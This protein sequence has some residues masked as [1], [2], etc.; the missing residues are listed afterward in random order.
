[1]P[2]LNGIEYEVVDPHHE[3]INPAKFPSYMEFLEYCTRICYKSDPTEESAEDFVKR[4]S[5]KH[6]SVLEHANCIMDI[7]TVNQ[8]QLLLDVTGVFEKND[9]NQARR[10]FIFRASKDIS[11]SAPGGSVL[12][13][14]G[15]LR[16]WMELMESD[17]GRHQYTTQPLWADM[18]ERLQ[19]KWPHFFGEHGHGAESAIVDLVDENPLTNHNKLPLCEMLKH[20][21][22]TCNLVGDRTMSHQLVR[23]RIS[24]YSQESQRFCDY[25]KKGFK[26]IVPP[27]ILNAAPEYYNLWLNDTINDYKVYLKLKEAG[28]PAED[29]RS[30]LPNAT[31]TEVVTTNT[32]GIWDHVF[33]QRP[34]NKKAQWQIKATVGG[35]E[36]EFTGL[37]PNVFSKPHCKCSIC[38][39]TA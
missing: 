38:K 26:F 24:S 34:R 19:Q 36:A 29:R 10:L 21:T 22:L 16:M 33:N 39:R 32:L 3:F 37:L 18:R 35:A 30:K 15:N 20:M 28:I 23:H 4:I 14:S 5:S 7:Q 13:L 2:E 11:G 9:T 17:H 8:E 25:G 1:M 12:R 31:K 27:K 6:V